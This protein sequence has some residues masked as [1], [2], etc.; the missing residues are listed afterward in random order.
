MKK[1]EIEKE[2]GVVHYQRAGEDPGLILKVG[3]KRERK[4][5]IGNT[6]EIIIVTAKK[7]EITTRGKEVKTT[8]HIKNRKEAVAGVE[9]GP[10]KTKDYQ[11]M[12]S[13]K[14]AS[15]KRKNKVSDLQS[16]ATHSTTIRLFMRPI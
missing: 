5:S 11:M 6:I 14:S 7:V 2:I 12:I 13:M 8:M 3:K 15:R 9:A 4:E 10:I 16:E 1:K